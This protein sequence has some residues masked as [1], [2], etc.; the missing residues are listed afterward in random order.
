MK[1]LVSVMMG[2]TS[3]LPVMNKT[4]EILDYFKIP[5]EVKV[6]SA[7]RT[8]NETM[9]YTKSAKKR[10]IKVIIAGAGGAAHLPGVIAS[11]TILPVIGVPVYTKVLKGID[12]FLSILQ[13][14]SG[15]P[16]GSMSIGDAGAKNAGIFAVEI[17][18]LSKS[19][20]SKKLVQYKK[21]LAKKV[22]KSQKL[23]K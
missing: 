8:P 3:D 4:R 14:P 12:S 20:L 19:T 9:K 13:M 17:L 7:H 18:A 11:H 6:L 15:I 2:S 1:P 5:H 10:G 16:V 23:V 21:D 22:I